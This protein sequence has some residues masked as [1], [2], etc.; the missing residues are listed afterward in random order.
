MRE[1]HT[2]FLL[3]T[4]GVKTE[5]VTFGVHTEF[6]NGAHPAPYPKRI[7]AAQILALTRVPNVSELIQRQLSTFPH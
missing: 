3:K 4:E 7:F 1:W 2:S 5:G 6:T